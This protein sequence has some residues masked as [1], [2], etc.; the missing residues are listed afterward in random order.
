M[1][2]VYQVLIELSN[3]SKWI[4]EDCIYKLAWE[5]FGIGSDTAFEC[6]KQW[7]DMYT[8]KI[9]FSIMPA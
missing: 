2:P 7:A 4:E 6:L 9:G 3:E 8:V 5:K 1:E